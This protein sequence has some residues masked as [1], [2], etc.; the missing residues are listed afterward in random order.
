M[1]HDNSRSDTFGHPTS[2]RPPD[3]KPESKTARERRLRDQ[4]KVLRSEPSLDDLFTT[5]PKDPRT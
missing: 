5:T 3:P 4:R 2:R 1:T